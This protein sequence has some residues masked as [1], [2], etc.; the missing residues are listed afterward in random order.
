MMVLQCRCALITLFGLLH[1]PI[2]AGWTIGNGQHT[3][4]F[5][6]GATNEKNIITHR[7]IF[8]STRDR[9]CS[10]MR[11]R[12]KKF[13][14][15]S[16]SS[17]LLL[18]HRDS[19]YSDVH[20]NDGNEWDDDDEMI[21]QTKQ[22]KADVKRQQVEQQTME[23][24]RRTLEM[25]WTLDEHQDDC[26]VDEPVTCGGEECSDCD[27]RGWNVCRFCSG[28]TFLHWGRPNGKHSFS[29]CNVCNQGV[30]TCKSCSGTGWVAPWMTFPVVQ[31]SAAIH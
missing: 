28:R 12:H 22:G 16:P 14:S 4:V 18:G 15:S 30:E 29:S 31:N 8:T 25:K 21:R 19:L 23:M 9:M 10:P 24:M 1:A 20:D 13:L 3:R 26:V 5:N 27:T 6:V 7:G 11:R 17:L 2:A